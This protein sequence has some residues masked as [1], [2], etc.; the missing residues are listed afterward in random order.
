MDKYFSAYEVYKEGKSLNQVAVI[1][2]VTRQCV[3]KAFVARKLK[4]RSTKPQEVQYF[5]GKKFTKRSSGYFSLTT[6]K[7]T[8]MHRY[9]WEFFNGKIPDG[10][11]I[12][13]IDETR[14][15]NSIENLECLS[16]SMH[17]KKYSPHNNQF[18]KGRKRDPHRAI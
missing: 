13:H 9:V 12:H 2:K 17:T 1:F 15:N 4:M 7:R 3:Y 10:F 6:G 18:T 8:L 11:D 16:K 5:D 14:D